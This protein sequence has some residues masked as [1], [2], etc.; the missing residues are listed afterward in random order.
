M[1]ASP[2]PSS[3]SFWDTPLYTRTI[4][5]GP[6]HNA[7]LRSLVLEHTAAHPSSTVGVRNAEKTTSDVLR[8]PHP[9]IDA[10]RQWIL[11]AACALNDHVGAGRDAAG[12][13]QPMVAEAW[14]VVY[15]L[16]GLHHL[17]SH[18]D[19][20]WSGVYYVATGRMR[21]GSGLLQFIDP[22]PAATAREPGRAAHHT[23][24]PFPGLL[25]AFP[26]WLRH[27]ATP[28]AGDAERVAIAFNVGFPREPYRRN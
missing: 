6:Q 7:A 1:T 8:W 28:Y 10:L 11:E 14:A 16:E 19:A 17:H 27:W 25:V 20:A 24:T 5:A 23:L 12:R 13:Q 15:H 3:G 4:D 2:T 9:A 22:R 18:H 26:A 21:S